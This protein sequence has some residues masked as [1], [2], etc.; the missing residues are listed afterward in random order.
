M[1]ALFY[2]DF[3]HCAYEGT[4]R[5]RDSMKTANLPP[6]EFVQKQIGSHQVHV[7][8]KNNVE[9]RKS[10]LNPKVT[11]IVGKEL[12]ATLTESE[13][14]VINFAAEKGKIS[15]SDA[16]RLIGKDWHAGKTTL[17]GLVARKVFELRL[18]SG[19][20]RVFETICS[21]TE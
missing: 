19:K 21:K 13:K 8:L 14:I 2:L 7:T 11:E 4:R 16:A 5:M 1:E 20:E 17:E 18:K 10:F 6:P 9:H 3:V 15:V 12:F